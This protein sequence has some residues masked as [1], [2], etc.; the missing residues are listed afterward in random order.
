MV[1]VYYMGVCE[2]KIRCKM[3]DKLEW[4]VN[5]IIYVWL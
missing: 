2:V 5:W 4:D 3:D 1:K